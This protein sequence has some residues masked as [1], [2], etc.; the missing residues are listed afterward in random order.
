[1][2]DE[3]EYDEFVRARLPHLLRLGR[4]LTAD[5][6][7]AADL[8]TEALAPVLAG[9]NSSSA[10]TAEDDV[11]R[12]MVRL[13]KHHQLP[14]RSTDSGGER[15]DET[16]ADLAAMST[17]ERTLVALQ[18]LEHLTDGQAADLAQCSETRA[19]AVAQRALSDL[20]PARVQAALDK[21]VPVDEGAVLTDVRRDADR[22]RKRSS[23][24]VGSISVAVTLIAAALITLVVVQE[25]EGA[26][27][28]SEKAF[29]LTASSPDRVWAVTTAP[30]CDSC[31]ELWSGDG[32]DRGWELVHTFDRPASTAELLMAP[33]GENGWAWFGRDYLQAT[34][35]EG[36]SWVIPGIDLRD[37][38]VDVAVAGT[39]AWVLLQA[40]QELH[41]WTSELGSDSW[42]EAT[43]PSRLSGR[44]SLAPRG[45]DMWLAQFGRS[46]VALTPVASP[47]AKGTPVPSC[48]V[49]PFPPRQ[50]PEGEALW[51]TC[52]DGEPGLLV[53]RSLDGVAWTD[54]GR[55]AFSAADSIPISDE[56]TLVR[57][58]DGVRLMGMRGPV[59]VP[60][61]LQRGVTVE[62]GVF[63]D[64]EVGF[65]LTSAGQVLR[66]D[67]GG[68]SWAEIG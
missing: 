37:S 10:F 27:G 13:V 50:S 32:T 4:A 14:P 22:L 51:V 39:H 1:M 7:A 53:K 26:T 60:L 54:V 48:A 12:N 2:G 18:L 49:A 68:R 20:D 30:D 5:D 40:G 63:V 17:Q 6:D 47:D 31:S 59:E 35:D 65:L 24:L 16:W 15:D 28:L 36:R 29:A 67:D 11:R 61:E 46:E 58:S 8:V 19:R 23:I 52:A 43:A 44:V 45:D 33:D 56:A 21:S 3:A 42:E 38:T 34:H 64:S 66:S 9:W 57:T 55:S 41:L 62:G 25:D